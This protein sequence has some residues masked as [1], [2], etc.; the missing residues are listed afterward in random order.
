MNPLSQPTGVT[1]MSYEKRSL[2]ERI[3]YLHGVPYRAYSGRLLVLD[4]GMDA[5]SQ[6]PYARW[7]RCPSSESTLYRWLGY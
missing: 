5:D 2:F 7:V 3:L 4:C 6:T 1:T